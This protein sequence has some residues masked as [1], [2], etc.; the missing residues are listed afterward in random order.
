MRN[1]RSPSKPWRASHMS[2]VF[3][4]LLCFPSF[5]GASVF[6]SY[7]V[8]S[9][10]PSKSCGPFRSLNTMYEAGKLYVR[11][12]EVT[13]PRLSWISWIHHYLWENTLFIYVASSVLLV[14]I[15][16]HIQIVNGQRKVI[17]LLKEQIANEGE[18]K[19]FL[20]DRLHSVYNKRSRIQRGQKSIQARIAMGKE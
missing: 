2:T 7:T 15:Y 11:Q 4:T 20:I 13:N 9:V 17:N 5:L 14:I 18:D 8:W 6:L 19:C 3:L 1:C 12:L 10:T 16:F